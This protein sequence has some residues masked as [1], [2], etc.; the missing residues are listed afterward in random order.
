MA[1]FT[2]VGFSTLREVA[3]RGSFTA[4]AA[5]LGYT[6]SAVSRQIGAMETAAGTPLVLRRARGVELTEHGR[7][8]LRHAVALLDQ[9]DGARRELAGLDEQAAGRLRVG[10]FATA[11]GALLPAALVAFRRRHARVDVAL[12]EGM[13]PAQ[14][15]RVR[16]GTT[17]L[18]VVGAFGGQALDVDGLILDP[19]LDDPLLIAVARSHPL[20]GRTRVDAEELVGERWITGGTDAD[21]PLLGVWPSLRGRA[22]VAF[23]AR[24][25]TA[26]LGLV[27]AGLGITVVP[28]L[29]AA[30]VRPDVALVRVG[31]DA[32]MTRS[33]LVATRAGEAPPPYADAFGEELRGAAA[34]VA[35]D[36]QRRLRGG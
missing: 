34:H 24:E 14:L 36:L 20:A 11:V 17:D 2:L 13:T 19:L 6:Q 35:A 12:H 4:A 7:A 22:R 23:V 28:G 31:D 30:A 32:A 25:W 27:A 1:D 3:E 16:A 10:A 33:V 5:A 21:N 8:L 18:A 15:R 29:A 26:K 9:V